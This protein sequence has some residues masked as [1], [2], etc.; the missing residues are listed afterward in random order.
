MKEILRE[1]KIHISKVLSYITLKLRVKLW[2]MRK[3]IVSKE[4]L[5]QE[6]KVSKN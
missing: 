2:E 5:P 3:Q 4:K 1:K 6:E